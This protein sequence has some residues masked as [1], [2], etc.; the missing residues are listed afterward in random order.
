M[1]IECVDM[2]AKV[3]INLS[4][5]T[6]IKAETPKVEPIK[7][8]PSKPSVPPPPVATMTVAELQEALNDHFDAQLEVDGKIGPMTTAAIVEAE[9]FLNLA[10]DGKPDVELYEALSILKGIVKDITPTVKTEGGLKSTDYSTLKGEYQN[11]WDTCVFTNSKYIQSVCASVIA[12]Q[13]RY[14]AVS[15]VTTVPWQVIAVIHRMEGGGNFGTHLHNGDSLKARTVQ[16][17]AG[18][19]KTGTPPFTWEVSAIDALGYDGLS[20]QKDW[21]PAKTLHFLEGYNGWGYR[22]GAGQVTV[23]ARR[24]PY[25]WAN[26]N[27]YVSGKYVADGVFDPKAV[28]DQI[29]AAALLKVL[30][31]GTPA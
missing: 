8:E 28:S 22:T 9:K 12:N 3:L 20:G 6:E 13:K 16:V 4:L 11:L 31:Y 1:K 30:K 5:A 26:T 17:P 24:S 18:R 10:A 27:Q 15:K 23:P 14:E 21:S 25:L 29:G 2:L 7:T 19:P